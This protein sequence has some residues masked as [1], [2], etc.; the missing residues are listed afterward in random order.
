[1]VVLRFTLLSCALALGGPAW[2]Q[3]GWPDHPI[4]FIVPFP[5]GGGIDVIAISNNGQA[6]DLGAS[7]NCCIRRSS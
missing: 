1:M 6:V 2:S 7:E 5:A 3:A 4:Q